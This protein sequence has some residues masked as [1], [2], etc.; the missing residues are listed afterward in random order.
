MSHVS[1]VSGQG[2]SVSVVVPWRAG[3]RQRQRVWTWIR[4]YWE[5][6]YPEFE[7]IEIDSGDEPFTRGTSINAGVEKSSGDVLIL[8]DA[9][10]LVAHVEEAVALATKGYWVIAY[11]QGR[12]CSLREETTE[13][14]LASDP[15]GQIIE[16]TADQ[17]RAVIDAFSGCLVMPRAA[18]ERVDGFDPRFL[19]WG[20]E[21]FA[22]MY[23]LDTLWR[24]YERASGYALH[25]YHEHREEER[26]DQPHIKE[27][28]ALV[29]EYQLHFGNPSSMGRYIRERGSNT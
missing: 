9:D 15:H 24:P 5:S 18:F 21:D 14:L 25:F 16:P 7:L 29:E 28:K 26:F 10:T 11:A 27:N 22:F 1:D 2:A 6:H 23:A 12:Y 20:H 3:D 8:S 13:K 17:C 4:E 19:G